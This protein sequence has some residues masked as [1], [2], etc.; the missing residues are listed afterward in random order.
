MG[1]TP[2]HTTPPPKTLY[3]RIPLY[4]K[5]MIG[6]VLGVGLGYAWKYVLMPRAGF[7]DVNVLKP[8][9]NLILQL[10]RLLATP[11]I[12]VAVVN[13]IMKARAGGSKPGKLAW[14]LLSNTTV[15]ILVGLLVA[16]VLRPGMHIKLVP[17]KPLDTRPFDPEGQL[18]SKIPANLIDGF[19]QNEIITIIILAIAL[20]VA[21]RIVRNRQLA[22]GGVSEGMRII[23]GFL[24]IAFDVIMV[25]LHWLFELV[26]FAV[27]IVVM[28]TVATEGIGPI[29]H[30]FFFVLAVL[31]ALFLQAGFYLARLTW[32]SWVSPTRF[33][34]GAIDPLIMA[35]STASSAATLPVTYDAV[36]KKIGVTE[37]SASMGVMVGGTFN[38]DGTALYEAMAALFIS[39]AIG[40][41]LGVGH[42]VL[43]VFMAILASVGA[44]GIP[45]AGLVTMLAV[46]SA[47]KLPT[48]FIPLLLP[49]DWFLDRCR[50]AI[51][52]MGDMSVTCLLE[53]KT[54]PVEA[55]EPG[56]YVRPEVPGDH[57]VPQAPRIPS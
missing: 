45:E 44:A 6:M 41:H 57:I 4:I 2:A 28:R 32:G 7:P 14:L 1:S 34:K 16:N 23:D 13:A 46:F 15:A 19:Q 43:M 38:H 54:R 27:L 47:L 9:G 52:V 3:G 31:L 53:G 22:A 25:M 49:L 35:F 10:L 20:G 36:R 21:L 17:D 5:I 24:D 30:M 48:E 50:T 55:G 51:N 8:W 40:Q 18:L 39:Q 11:L 26:P 12:F 37:E 42:Q 56:L 33:L 29:Q